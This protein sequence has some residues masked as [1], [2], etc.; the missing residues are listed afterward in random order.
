MRIKIFLTVLL[1]VSFFLSSNIGNIAYGVDNEIPVV[2]SE[3]QKIYETTLNSGRVDGFV[4]LEASHSLKNKTD[5]FSSRYNGGYGGG[6]P[7]VHVFGLDPK[8]GKQIFK[9]VYNDNAYGQYL[10]PDH[11]YIARYFSGKEPNIRQSTLSLGDKGQPKWKVTLPHLFTDMKEDGNFYYFRRGMDKD[12]KPE[13]IKYS[14][15]GTLLW[16]YSYLNTEHY[17]P[18][19][20]VD[21]QGRTV[22]FFEK[23][24]K[25]VKSKIVYLS[26][27]GKKKY[28]FFLDKGFVHS[29][30]ASDQIFGPDGSIYFKTWNVDTEK[31]RIHALDPNGKLMWSKNT[32]TLGDLQVGSNGTLFFVEFKGNGT[33]GIMTTLRAYSK[34][35][36]ELWSYQRPY[37]S[38]SNHSIIF[39]DY[40]TIYFEGEELDLKG[41]YIR[42]FL[43]DSYIN[44]YE[45][46]SIATD[47][48]LFL[49]KD[50]KH[51][52]VGDATI[53]IEKYKLKI[54]N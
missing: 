34:Q 41:S 15:N 43:N 16:K 50:M 53:N 20:H 5:F 25:D 37:I 24:S 39:S 6:D 31:Y 17:I 44:Y 23:T 7:K 3:V 12:E 54:S 14:R 35:G 49:F 38:Q 22:I 11:E 13:V 27:N 1:I 10:G 48:T 28:G 36:K 30:L 52:L 21:L 4:D 45:S 33:P 19:L 42:R 18:G 47:G 40:S 32:D 9:N 29:Y 26:T 46:T 51:G 8:T 2:K